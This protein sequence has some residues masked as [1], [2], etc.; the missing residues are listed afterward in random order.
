MRLLLDTINATTNHALLLRDLGLIVVSLVSYIPLFPKT[1]ILPLLAHK[2]H[3]SSN[4]S[5]AALMRNK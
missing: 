1:Y 5:S 3:S 4:L 2:G